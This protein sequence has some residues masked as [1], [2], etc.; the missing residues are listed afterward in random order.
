MSILKLRDYQQNIINKVSEHLLY[1]KRCCVSLATGGGKTV[2]FS[3]LVTQL[4]ERTLICVHREELIIQTSNTLKTDHDLIISKSKKE[5][6]E[7]VA[8]AMVQTLWSRIK[9]KKV[10]VNDYDNIIIDECHRGEFMKVLD[11]FN[12]NVIGFTATPNYE[13]TIYFYK[14][15]KCGNEEDKADKCCKNKLKKYKRNVPLAEYYD[16]L[17]EGVEINELIEQGFLVK[18]ENYVLPVNTNQLVYNEAK[19]D[20]TEESIS[21]VFGSPSAIKNTIDTFKEISLG[22]KTILF[23]PNTLVNKK[24]YEAMIKEG[25]NAKMYD[26]NNSEEN[27]HELV[28][29]FKNTPDAILLNVQ[30]FTTGFDCTDVEV[31]FLNKKTKSINLYLQMVGRGGRIT[32]KILKPSFK[33][34]D[35][36]NNNEDFDNWSDK[37]DWKPYF[38]NTETKTVGTPSPAATRNCHACDSVIAA[39]SL[40]CEVCGVERVYTSGGVVG[41]PMLNGKPVIPEPN[42]IIEYC[43]KNNLDTLIARKI[44]Y[45]Y[46]SRMFIGVKPDVFFKAKANGKLY[47]RALDRFNDYYFAIQGSSLEGNK[48]RTRQSF[49]NEIIK[50]IERRYTTS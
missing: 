44:V 16:T 27:R 49:I 29:W 50:N 7:N 34:I 37:R 46:A 4:K 24:L 48:V 40:I 47:N 39:N 32:D 15:L 14:C 36:G 26:S 35:M 10:D 22:K 33:V 42:K 8:V 11:L 9:S 1:N 19:G 45:D 12:G 18:D 31:V 43:Q 17:I 28:E 23:N 5:P 20:Y 30:V 2:I 3:N 21:L 13:K 6:I 25:L 38:Y 41:L